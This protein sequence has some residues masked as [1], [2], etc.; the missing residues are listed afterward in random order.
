[1]HLYF[2]LTLLHQLCS[3]MWYCILVVKAVILDLFLIW[4]EKYLVF[5]SL[6]MMLLAVIFF[7]FWRCPLSDWGNSFLFLVFQ[8]YL[9]GMDVESCHLHLFGWSYSF[10]LCTDWFSN[11]KL[12]LRHWDKAPWVVVFKSFLYIATFDLLTFCWRFCVCVHEGY[13]LLI[14]FCCNVCMRFCYQN[15]AG[16]H[17]RI[18]KCSLLFYSLEESR[19]AIIS[20]LNV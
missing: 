20:S 14:F 4:V 17:K 13:R 6:S 9:S 8:E 5:S 1:M 16:P 3:P 10:S 7:F 19:T 2:F 11:V 15:N 18:G 12:V